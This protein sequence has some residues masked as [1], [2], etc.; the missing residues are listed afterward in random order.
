MKF[1]LD[2]FR[3]AHSRLFNRVKAPSKALR[4]DFSTIPISY[5]SS[6]ALN[7]ER[8]LEKFQ[9]F[10]SI[11]TI[12]ITT[13]NQK[14]LRCSSGHHF[15][16]GS[17]KSFVRFFPPLPNGSSNGVQKQFLSSCSVLMIPS[18]SSLHYIDLF[19]TMDIN[20]E[21]SKR[22]RCE[23]CS[24]NQDKYASLYDRLTANDPGSSPANL[25][26]GTAPTKTRSQAINPPEEKYVESERAYYFSR[27]VVRP[28]PPACD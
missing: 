27:K 23:P 3:A 11:W 15:A 6:T 12:L 22:L 28:D 10:W 2:R 17:N 16:S 24:P 7:I 21:A 4:K 9:G 19:V 25:H 1:H 5:R 20:Y 13:L 26:V 8:R 18:R 14:D